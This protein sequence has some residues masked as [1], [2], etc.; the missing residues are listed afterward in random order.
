MGSAS[1]FVLV[2]ELLRGQG[3]GNVPVTGDAVDD[4]AVNANL[5]GADGVKLGQGVDDAFDD[6]FLFGAVQLGILQFLAEIHGAESVLLN[7]DALYGGACGDVGGEGF[8]DGPRQ[9]FLKGGFGQSRL[10]DDAPGLYR[11]VVAVFIDEKQGDFLVAH[12]GGGGFGVLRGG[13]GFAVFLFLFVVLFRFFVIG[14]CGGFRNGGFIRGGKSF[15]PHRGEKAADFRLKDKCQQYDEKYAGD[16]TFLLH[17]IPSNCFCIFYGVVLRDMTEIVAAK[18]TL[19][20]NLFLE[21][22]YE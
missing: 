4:T 12:I 14:Q 3:F 17:E 19:C 21:V 2:A 6:E 15:F 18:A 13:R 16:D 7:I 10:I 20:Y 1:C 22:R 9:Q 11:Q 5:N 8:G